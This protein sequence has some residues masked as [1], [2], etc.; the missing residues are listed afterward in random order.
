MVRR[1]DDA[2]L[3]LA[4]RGDVDEAR[5]AALLANNAPAPPR[6]SG[7]PLRCQRRAR[8]LLCR[9]PWHATRHLAQVMLLLAF[10]F[11]G[12]VLAVGDADG[13]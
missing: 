1:G 4:F 3:R 10:I 13:G 6:P 9:S 12:T 2:L 5:P 7:A 11:K 8:E